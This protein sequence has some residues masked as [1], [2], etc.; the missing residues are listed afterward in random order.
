M[1][2]WVGGFPIF[3]PRGQNMPF[4]GG[5]FFGDFLMEKPLLRIC[6]KTLYILY[7]HLGHILG[8]FLL[9]YRK[10]QVNKQ[11]HFN[12]HNCLFILE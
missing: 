3:D 9:D 2:G 4:K 1:R 7:F 5:V 12:I 11:S 6:D 10:P 8:L